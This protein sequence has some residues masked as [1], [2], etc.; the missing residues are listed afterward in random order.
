MIKLDLKDNTIDN[1]AKIKGEEAE[2]T[3]ITTSDLQLPFTIGFGDNQEDYE[4]RLWSVL[5]Y[6]YTYLVN[7]DSSKAPSYSG[8]GLQEALKN[9]A[10]KIE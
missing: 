1:V 8:S 2:F 9:I 10:T 5:N 6:L 7:I 4:I 3:K